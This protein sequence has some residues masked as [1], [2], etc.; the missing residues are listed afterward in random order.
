MTVRIALAECIADLAESS[1]RFLEIGLHDASQTADDDYEILGSYDSELS[2]LRTQVAR[3][4]SSLLSDQVGLQ[5]EIDW[6]PSP[7]PCSP[8]PFCCRITQSRRL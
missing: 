6:S 8:L 1:H 5:A 2:I 4:V 3:A 7:R